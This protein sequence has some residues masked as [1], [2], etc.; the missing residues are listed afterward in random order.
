MEQK[1]PLPMQD[2][3]QM[4][5]ERE[6][7][8]TTMKQTPVLQHLRFRNISVMKTLLRQFIQPV[9]LEQVVVMEH[10]LPHHQ[11]VEL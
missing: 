4:E 7:V 8:S 3:Q 1:E 11:K 5:V 2:M 9:L 10:A 6:Q